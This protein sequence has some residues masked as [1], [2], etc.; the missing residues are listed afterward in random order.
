MHMN[1]FWQAPLADT[2]ANSSSIAKGP[3][4]TLDAAQWLARYAEEAP[5]SSNQGSAAVAF[6]R[7]FHFKEAFSPKFVADTPRPVRGQRDN[8]AHQQNARP[9]LDHG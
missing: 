4:P 6:Q 7:W 8:S 5:T 1:A 2:L 9:L 3:A